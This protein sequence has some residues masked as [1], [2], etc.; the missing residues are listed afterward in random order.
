[1][2]LVEA[3][4]GDKLL[5]QAVQEYYDLMLPRAQDAV[6]RSHEASIFMH[7]PKEEIKQM[8]AKMGEQIAARARAMKE[9]Q[10]QEA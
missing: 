1:M 9:Q 2:L 4:K 7:G 3:Y 8:F 6:K 5:E 10:Q